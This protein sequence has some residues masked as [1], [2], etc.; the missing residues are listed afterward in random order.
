MGKQRFG[1]G[2]KGWASLGYTE[3]EGRAFQEELHAQRARDGKVCAHEDCETLTLAHGWEKGNKAGWE[4]CAHEDC[5]T[6]TLVREWEK[7]NKAK[8]AGW[9]LRE[10]YIVIIKIYIK[11]RRLNVLSTKILHML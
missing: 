9:T 1:L 3:R 7:G 5:E 8:P 11:E 10:S 6:L 4:V 2:I